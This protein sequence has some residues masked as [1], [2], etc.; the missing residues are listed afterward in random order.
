MYMR[1]SIKN[2]IMGL[3]VWACIIWGCCFDPEQLGHWFKI[4]AILGVVTWF[5]WYI[6]GFDNPF[7]ESEIKEE[8]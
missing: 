3:L 6:C 1:E 2:I 5:W 4:A 7:V 8:V